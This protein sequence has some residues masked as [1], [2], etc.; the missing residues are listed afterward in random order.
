MGDSVQDARY[1]MARGRGDCDD[2]CVLLATLLASIGIRS[3]FVVVTYNARYWQHVYLA[4]QLPSRLRLV[5]P[6][7]GK[8]KADQNEWVFFDPTPE[9]APLGWGRRLT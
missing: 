1:T 8:V 4:V 7:T 2:K 5:D 6:A 9:R 3:R